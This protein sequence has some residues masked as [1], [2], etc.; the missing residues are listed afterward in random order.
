ME[1]F[2]DIISQN[3]LLSC[4][5]LAAIN[6]L[7]LFAAIRTKKDVLFL[8]S[9][10]S[11]FFSFVILQNTNVGWI[12]FYEVLIYAIP[13]FADVLVFF[14]SLTLWA[15]NQNSKCPALLKIIGTVL[16]L[17]GL[18]VFLICSKLKLL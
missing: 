12:A 7:L 5:T 4:F 6:S 15:N 3:D 18:T 8:L 14:A 2:I 10:I 16:I 9:M 11:S 17:I 1:M 13:A